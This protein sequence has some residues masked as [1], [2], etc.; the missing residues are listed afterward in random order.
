M[1]RFLV[2]ERPGSGAGGGQACAS[3]DVDGKRCTSHEVV[4]RRAVSSGRGSEAHPSLCSEG[5]RLT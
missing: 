1:E 4:E 3:R 5:A 2:V